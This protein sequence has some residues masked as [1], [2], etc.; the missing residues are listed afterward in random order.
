MRKKYDQSIE[1]ISDKYDRG[2]DELIEEV[3]EKKEIIWKQGNTINSLTT[4]IENLKK[5][6]EELQKK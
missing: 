4:E 3:Q 6:L 5:R 1:L 2:M